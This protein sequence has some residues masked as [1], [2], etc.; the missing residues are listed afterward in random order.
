MAFKVSDFHDLVRLLEQHP[1]WRAELRRLVLTEEILSLPQLVRD[2]AQEVRGLAEAQARTEVRLTELAEAQARTE[3]RV[4]RLEDRVGALEGSDLERTYRER[5]YAFFQRILKAIHAVAPQ[6]LQK[7]LDDAVGAGR[8]TENE[9]EDILYADLIVSGR[10][11]S[12]P[13][14]LVAEVSA[15]VRVRD[16]ERAVRRAQ[17]LAKAS[18]V[19]TLAAVAGREI[20]FDAETEARDRG[21]WRVLDGVILPPT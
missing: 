11:D 20:Q 10:R 14:Y 6:D 2:L 7:M 19:P 1:E 12:Q 3:Q 9:K 8:I 18:G 17:L 13:T 16:V 4:G 21:V 15:T 5:S